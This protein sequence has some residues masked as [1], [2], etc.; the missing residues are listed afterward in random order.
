M[1]TVTVDEIQ[2]NLAAYL[3]QV[4]VDEIIIVI[5]AGQAIAEIRAISFPVN[6][7]RPFSL[8]A[9]KFVVPDD[10]DAPLPEDSL[11]SCIYHDFSAGAS[12]GTERSNNYSQNSCQVYFEILRHLS[13]SVVSVYIPAELQ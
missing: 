2:T 9:G 10:F 13:H 6:Q 7:P 3:H 5:Q 11:S 4:K 1:L 8:C 12:V